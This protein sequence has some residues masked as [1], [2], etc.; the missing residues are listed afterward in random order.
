MKPTNFPQQCSC[1]AQAVSE[2]STK[3]N[4]NVQNLLLGR[5]RLILA[6]SGQSQGWIA[7]SQTTLHQR[8]WDNPP[9]LKSPPSPLLFATTFTHFLFTIHTKHSVQ[10]LPKPPLPPR[11]YI[12]TCSDLLEAA[13]PNLLS[14]HS[15][16][17]STLC[18]IVTRIPILT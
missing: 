14:C 15:P 12:C 1:V 7:T 17:C 4:Q 3:R 9:S 16:Q 8:D 11:R 2:D 10:L 6:Q 5:A 13:R 18:L